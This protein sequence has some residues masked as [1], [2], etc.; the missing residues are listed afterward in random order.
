MNVSLMFIFSGNFKFET[1][2][3]QPSQKKL[4]TM[5]MQNF[6]GANKVHYEKCGSGVCQLVTLLPPSCYLISLLLC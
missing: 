2:L 1:G 3:L 4:K 6:A 5:L